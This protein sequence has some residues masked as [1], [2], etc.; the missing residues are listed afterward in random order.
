MA[1][2]RVFYS[3]PRKKYVVKRN[4]CLG[5]VDIEDFDDKDAAIACVNHLRGRRY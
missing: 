5:W 3:E 4:T 2:F 1:K